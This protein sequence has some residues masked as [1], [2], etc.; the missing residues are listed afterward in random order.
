MMTRNYNIG[1]VLA[2]AFLC[3]M[4]VVMAQR[5]PTN[6]YIFLTSASVELR[7]RG[8]TQKE[9]N[10]FLN[11]WLQEDDDRGNRIF[12]RRNMLGSGNA[13]NSTFIRS[14]DI[15]IIHND[16]SLRDLDES[17]IE[18][19][20]INP[21]NFRDS[22]TYDLRFSFTYNNNCTVFAERTDWIRQ[23]SING[24]VDREDED[25]DNLTDESGY[26]FEFSESV[27]V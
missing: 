2:L 19:E 5:C 13:W 27:S 3:S 23:S 18:I 8:G 26:P 12:A 10:S 6:S 22:I 15:P 1:L 21:E 4:T 24:S 20:F 7:M 11:I 16:I 17:D 25:I 14:F 9:P